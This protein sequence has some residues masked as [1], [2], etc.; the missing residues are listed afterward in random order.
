MKKT[1]TLGTIVLGCC[2][3]ALTQTSGYYQLPSGSASGDSRNQSRGH[4]GSPADQFQSYSGDDPMAMSA[5][6]SAK[7]KTTVQGC[8][9]QSADGLFML[10]DPSGNSYQLNDSSSRLAQFVGKEIRVDGFGLYNSSSAVPGAISAS[11][12]SAQQID[13]S[14]VRKIADSCHARPGSR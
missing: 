13:V 8:L 5:N 1:L 9:S 3:F 6:Q 2:L 12:I 7:Q 4:Q 10:S 14:R 11:P